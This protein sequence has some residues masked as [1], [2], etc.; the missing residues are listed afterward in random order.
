[1]SAADLLTTTNLGHSIRLIEVILYCAR[2]SNED[3]DRLGRL[4]W[5]GHQT[6]VAPYSAAS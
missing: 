5:I 4:S 3:E 2:I 1:M 6:L